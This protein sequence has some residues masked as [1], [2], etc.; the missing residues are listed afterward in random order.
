MP[1]LRG[2][3]LIELMIVVAV[4]TILTTIAWPSYTRYVKRGNR[5]QAQQFMLDMSS[6][7]EAYLLDARQYT[8]ALDS[9][10]LNLSRAGW[11]CTATTCS[12]ANY[13]ISV[14]A[15]AG[16]PPAYTINATAIG[17]QATDGNLSLD[18]LGVKTPSNLW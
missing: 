7:E 16:P 18:N 2:F 11:T 8:S 15:T 6:R 1:R 12:N 3:T 13:N 14:T 9:T 4:I 5:A 10:G 17:T